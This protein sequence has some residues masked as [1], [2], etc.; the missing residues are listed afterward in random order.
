MDGV[1]TRSFSIE[2]MCGKVI[3]GEPFAFSRWGDGEW[4]CVLGYQGCNTDHHEYTED[5]RRDLTSVL[6]GAPKYVMALQPHAVR[7]MGDEIKRWC[8][9]NRVETPWADAGVLHT[10]SIR[11]A[12]EP[13]LEALRPRGVVLVGPER[14]GALRLF[15]VVEHVT[16]PERN[17]HEAY[18]DVLERA[19][20]AILRNPGAVA[21]LSAS[22]SANVLVHHLHEAHPEATLIDAGSVWE[23]Y[24]GVSNRTYHRKILERLAACA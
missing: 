2:E 7:I 13:L 9:D 23:P 14:L 21:C 24:A 15:P 8:A 20:V 5:L 6:L 12:L 4:R 19:S 17:C 1:I 18:A 11:D 22:M 3:G 16:V 10:A